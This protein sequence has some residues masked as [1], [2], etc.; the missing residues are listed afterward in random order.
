M[1]CHSESITSANALALLR[2][3]DVV[4]DASD[5][6]PTRYLLSDACSVLRKPL[7]S[8]AA[9]GT[10]GQLAVYCYGASGTKGWVLL[11]VTTLVAWEYGS[12]NHE[13]SW[14]L[15]CQ[16]WLFLFGGTTNLPM[17]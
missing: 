10:D 7:V 12:A 13:Y 3:Y 16:E 17:Y 9:I 11:M 15:W 14:V 8:G 2:S 4:A 6:A 1:T 5:N